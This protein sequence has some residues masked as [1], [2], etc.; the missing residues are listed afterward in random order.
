MSDQHQHTPGYSGYCVDCLRGRLAEVVAERDTL[1]ASVHELEEMYSALEGERNRFLCERDQ[2]RESLAAY[3]HASGIVEKIDHIDAAT[4]QAHAEGKRAAALQIER[5]RLRS[6]V[7]TLVADSCEDDEFIRDQAARV[8]PV[9][10]VQGDS[11]GVPSVADIVTSLV[12][13]NL[14]LR[15]Q[16][17]GHCE[18]IAKQSELLSKRAERG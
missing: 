16:I 6:H 3:K 13:Q 11:C 7:E 17:T 12:N 1:Q 2:L 9:A 18:R 15:E 14:A 5:D 10:M 4:R 8:L